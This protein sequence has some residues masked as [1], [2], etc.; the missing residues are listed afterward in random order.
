MLAAALAPAGAAARPTDEL[1]ALVNSYRTAP[2]TCQGRMR[3]AV[4]A[5]SARRALSGIALSPGSILIAALDKAGYDA[6]VADAVHVAGPA[7]AQAAFEALRE[8]YCATL[9]SK[10]Y[11]DAGARHQGNEWT[12]VLA[13]AMPDPAAVL[14]AWQDAGR[15]V[16][17]ATNAAR[18][19]ARQCGGEWMDAAPPLEWNAMLASA[20]LAHSEDMADKRYFSH[21]GKDGREVGHRASDAGYRWRTVGENIARGQL[22]VNEVVAGWLDSPGHCH[23]VMNPRFTE[24]GAAYSVRGGRRPAAYWTQVFALPR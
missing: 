10:R 11:T 21:T 13:R 17:A 12:L 9:S 22:S 23:N 7:D 19:Q 24:M 4:P 6:E 14:P 3:A 16:L 15:N 5:L 8:A 20:A 18:S 1:L 2:A